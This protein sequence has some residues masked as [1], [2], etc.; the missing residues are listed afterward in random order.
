MSI[1]CDRHD[2]PNDQML[3][4]YLLGHHGE[5]LAM[6]PLKTH[7][8]LG[9]TRK[10]SNFAPMRQKHTII[11]VLVAV[12]A[13]I[14]LVAVG[15]WAYRHDRAMRAAL[16]EL[17]ARNQVDSVFTSDSAALALV[18]YYDHFWH[19][20]N[21]RMLAYYLLGRA[22][23]DMGEAPQ[24]IEAYQTAVERADTTASDC[25]F[26]LLRNVYGQMAEVFHAQNLPEDEIAAQKRFNHYSWVIGDTLSAIMG[27]GSLM[28]P[29]FLL[30]DTANM[31]RVAHETEQELLQY[32]RP[33]LAAMTHVGTTYIY[34]ERGEIEQAKIHIDQIRAESGIFDEDGCLKPGREMF[35]YTLGLYFDGINQIDSA[36]YYYRLVLAAGEPEAGYKGLLSVYSKRGI[37]DSIAKFAP[38]YADANDASHDSLRTAEVHKAASLYNY[39]RHL[40]QA[41]KE[42]QEK[43]YLKNMLIL[44]IIAVLIMGMMGY[45]TY[46]RQRE[47]QKRLAKEYLHAIRELEDTRQEIGA[48][49]EAAGHWVGKEELLT[50]K[51]KKEQELQHQIAILKARLRVPLVADLMSETAVTDII[52]H[53]HNIALPRHTND[54]RYRKL[55]APRSAKNEEWKWLTEMVR[56]HYPQFYRFVTMENALSQQEYKISLLSRLQFDTSEIATLLGTSLPT[57]SNARKRIAKKLFQLDSATLLDERIAELS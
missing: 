31:L 9:D 13:A 47:E 55:K 21:D 37:A 17:Q 6:S 18:S 43:Q 28:K 26:R 56:L 4:R 11:V 24:A 35:Y 38:L 34:I 23:A 19:R 51:E 5:N 52:Q 16:M 39:N 50:I 14:A 57:V 46:Q 30:S 48:L 25:D 3:A 44:I 45:Q 41:Q 32:G 33:D 7:E 15:V 8:V 49:H 12:A 54:D 53:F 10:W 27:R 2:R 22:H 29:Y 36:E 42:R 20:A 40:R 1:R